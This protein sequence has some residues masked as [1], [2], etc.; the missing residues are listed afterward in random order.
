MI[1]ELCQKEQEVTTLEIEVSFENHFYE[2]DAYPEHNWQV[3]ACQPCLEKFRSDLRT[4][5]GR[6]RNAFKDWSKRG[7]LTRVDF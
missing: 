4:L 7:Q 2:G 3:Q 6:S 5:L 1:C